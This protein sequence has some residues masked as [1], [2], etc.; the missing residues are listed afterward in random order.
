MRWQPIAWFCAAAGCAGAPGPDGSCDDGQLHPVADTIASDDACAAWLDGVRGRVGAQG[1]GSFVVWDRRTEDQLALVASAMHTLGAGWFADAGAPVE[2]GLAPPGSLGVLRL[3]FPPA[4]GD[5]TLGTLSPLYDLYHPDVPADQHTVGMA[6]IEP[7]HDFFVGLTDPQRIAWSGTG[8]FL[9]PGP[10]EPGPVPVYDPLEATTTPPTWA[11]AEPDAETLLVGFAAD[12]SESGSFSIGAVLDDAAAEDAIDELA[13]AGDEEG[14]IPYDPEVEV[15][16]AAA[17]AVGMS[18]GGLFDEQGQWV[19]V[20]VRGSTTDG[21]GP[22]A[23]AVRASYVVARL[24]AAHDAL[25][26]DAS[27]EVAPFLPPR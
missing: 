19:G 24:E 14:S 13:A 7:R 10:R 2:E 1:P 12:G 15:L 6:D 18:G 5:L 26:D 9:Q 20:L 4:D 25:P 17:A 22:Y 16:V 11:E 27:D 3:S 8:P 21:V 23:R